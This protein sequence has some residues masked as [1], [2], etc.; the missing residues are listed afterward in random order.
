ME[1]GGFFRMRF[2][3][4]RLHERSYFTTTVSGSVHQKTDGH[5]LSIRSYVNHFFDLRNLESKSSR[6]FGNFP[7]RLSLFF[8]IHWRRFQKHL[9]ILSV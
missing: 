1:N 2:T 6:A 8:V 9:T 5:H 3:I 4:D 7:F